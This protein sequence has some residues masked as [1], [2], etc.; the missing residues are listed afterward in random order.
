M[1][2]KVSGTGS[3]ISMCC[4]ISL[5]LWSGDYCPWFA[6]EENEDPGCRSC[7]S[8]LPNQ[9]WHN[10]DSNSGLTSRSN[11][12]FQHMMP[13]FHYIIQPPPSNLPFF[14]SK[15]ILLLIITVVVVITRLLTIHLKFN[16]RLLC[17]ISH[18]DAGVRVSNEW[19]LCSHTLL[20]C[21]DY[22]TAIRA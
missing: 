17:P 16:L 1:A 6:C 19:L 11:H 21:W 10:W 5:R 9:K 13:F 4:L 3:S 8:Q 15:P 18:C 2:A 14:F 20:L 22:L 7:P 12:F